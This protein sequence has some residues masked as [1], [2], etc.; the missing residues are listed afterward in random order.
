MLNTKI[1]IQ[2]KLDLKSIYKVFKNFQA[3]IDHK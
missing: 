1:Y 3:S 2:K